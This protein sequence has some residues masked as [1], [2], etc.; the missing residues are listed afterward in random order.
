MSSNLDAIRAA[1][2]AW[3]RYLDARGSRERTNATYHRRELAA[4]AM[5]L[6][7]GRL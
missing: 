6:L 4:L 1:F 5:R 7:T 2:N 3:R